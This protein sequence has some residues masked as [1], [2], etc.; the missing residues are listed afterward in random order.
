MEMLENILDGAA[1]VGTALSTP[2]MLGTWLGACAMGAYEGY[3][4]SK[5]GNIQGL[6]AASLAVGSFVSGIIS[7]GCKEYEFT[8]NFEP[9]F[10]FNAIG[11]FSL[12]SVFYLGGLV[13][14]KVM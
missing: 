10:A 14:G 12:P 5:T 2:I 1:K 8:G 4:T 3:L 9:E 7:S 13:A 6:P 11:C